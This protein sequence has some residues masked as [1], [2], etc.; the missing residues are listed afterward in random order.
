MSLSRV[1]QQHLSRPDL[2]R[3]R[4]VGEM[5]A[6]SGHDQRDGDRVPMLGD[7][8]ARLEAQADN[9]H[10]TAVGDLLKPER[11]RWLADVRC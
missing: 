8:L 10:R 4:A 3:L 5:Q 1:D 2:A 6:A 7:G 11:A 9:A